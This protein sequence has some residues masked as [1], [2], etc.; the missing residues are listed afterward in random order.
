MQ[1]NT[2]V[3][4]EAVGTSSAE[5]QTAQ[6]AGDSDIANAEALTE[7]ENQGSTSGEAASSGQDV[8][9]N[10]ET[11]SVDGAK[12]AALGVVKSEQGINRVQQLANKA[13]QADADAKYWKEQA[14][15]NARQLAQQQQMGQAPQTDQVLASLALN[16]RALNAEMLRSQE[17]QRLRDEQQA[18]D[19]AVKT[20]P[21]LDPSSDRYDKRADDLFF[22]AYMGIRQQG[23]TPA[24][25][26]K[27]IKDIL[28]T[29]TS[30]VA[31]ETE[32]GIAQKQ[33]NSTVQKASNYAGNDNDYANKK[34]SDFAEQGTDRALA[35]YL[36]ATDPR[37]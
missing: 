28:A 19:A 15:T 6:G 36:S 32:A 11:E 8:N 35:E 10:V 34:R 22:G 12:Q 23:G 26:V 29:H 14:E 18:I 4:N 1:D 5:S 37:K 20:M 17:A 16:Q 7:A 25:A 3:T 13:S 24:Q 30:K 21:E 9:T 27:M 33:S 31:Y 2:G